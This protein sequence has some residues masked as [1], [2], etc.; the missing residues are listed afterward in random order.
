VIVAAFI[1]MRNIQETKRSD[2]WIRSRKC[3]NGLMNIVMAGLRKPWTIL[4]AIIVK[5][6]HKVASGTKYLC[7]IV[8]HAAPGCALITGAEPNFTG[9]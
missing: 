7:P 8:P 4:S 1:T 5:V 3:E 6:F 2:G 9:L